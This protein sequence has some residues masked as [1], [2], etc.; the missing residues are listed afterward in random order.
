MRTATGHMR[1]ATGRLKT[2]TARPARRRV[3][4]SQVGVLVLLLALWNLL[5]W[6]PI[7]AGSIPSAQATAKAAFL[8]VGESDTWAALAVTAQAW[9]LSLLIAIAFA[10][11]IGM[12][13]G[14]F[15]FA[16]RSA[17]PLIDFLRSVPSIAILPLAALMYG[18]HVKTELV[19]AAPACFWPLVLQIQYGAREV[20]PVLLDVARSYRLTRVQTVW[21]VIVPSCLTYAIVGLRLAII[22]GLMACL[23]TEMLAGVPGIGFR[24]ADAQ[25]LGETLN[26]YGYTL[27][28]SVIGVATTM[29]ADRMASRFTPWVASGRKSSSAGGR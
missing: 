27:L 5:S 1:T 21:S 6:S 11:P 15:A 25:V 22:I 8:L 14:R 2:S 12:V 4:V 29:L 9:A 16:Y 26:V 3:R 13:L 17:Q 19:I 24:L 10:V 18:T 7:A 28:V 20:E 23:G